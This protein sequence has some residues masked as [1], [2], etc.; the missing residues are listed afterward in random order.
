MKKTNVQR[1]KRTFI[2][3]A[4]GL[5][6]LFF[7]WGCNTSLNSSATDEVE[8]IQEKSYSPV[9]SPSVTLSQTSPPRETLTPSPTLSPYDMT[10]SAN[11]VTSKAISQATNEAANELCGAGLISLDKPYIRNEWTLLNCES[12]DKKVKFTLIT[13]NDGTMHWNI[14]LPSSDY[15][16]AHKYTMSGLWLYKEPIN[17]EYV[18]MRPMGCCIDWFSNYGFFVDLYGLYRFDLESGELSVVLPEDKNSIGNQPYAV[19]ISSSVN[20]L[21]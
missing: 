21:L 3:I 11:F 12:T 20:S 4:L 2:F 13:R 15:P 1:K 16:W 5:Y 10:F 17:N 18:F 19:S 9:A 14:E 6:S 8:I 7:V